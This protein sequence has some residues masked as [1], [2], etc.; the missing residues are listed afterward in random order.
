MPDVVNPPPIQIRR[1]VDRFA[2]GI[3]EVFVRLYVDASRGIPIN[4]TSW[5][6]DP[7]LN[8][9]VGGA[10]DSQH[11][12]G[13]AV[14]VVGRPAEISEHAARLRAKGFVVVV[15]P[16]DQKSA[17]SHAQAWPAGAARRA[18]VFTALGL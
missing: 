15:R 5:Y 17:R 13:L 7:T 2:P 3:Y 12:F 6:R 16:L 10:P 9:T 18:G 4:V 14:D 11:L 8:L 1:V